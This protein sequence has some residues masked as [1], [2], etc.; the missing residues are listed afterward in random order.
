MNSNS[1]CGA[2]LPIYNVGCDGKP[3]PKEPKQNNRE[4]QAKELEAA[5]IPEETKRKI[6]TEY[7]RLCRQHPDWK[8]HRLM[9]KAGEKYN[10]KF[11]FE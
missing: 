6:A 4:L 1:L 7:M 10:V 5:N 11:E 3:I 8:A 2:K 9:R